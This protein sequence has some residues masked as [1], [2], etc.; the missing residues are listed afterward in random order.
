MQN[1]AHQIQNKGEHQIV[2]GEE[3]WIYSEHPKRI[4]SWVAPG[5]PS[6]SIAKPN[7]YG[8]KTILSVWWD[9][10]G[11]IYYELLKLGESVTT[12]Q[13]ESGFA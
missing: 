7:R 1:A 6:T 2:T 10:K 3:K 12:D 9:L 4:K 8:R 5:E 13:L 11:L